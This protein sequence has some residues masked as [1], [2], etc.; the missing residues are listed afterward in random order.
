ME[1]GMD[2]QERVDMNELIK[3]A[4]GF[5]ESG[6]DRALEN[7]LIENNFELVL[8]DVQGKTLYN[9]KEAVNGGQQEDINKIMGEANQD[10]QIY[11][12]KYDENK[13][14]Q[15]AIAV[16]KNR[17][18]LAKFE[19]QVYRIKL[20]VWFLFVSFI[21]LQGLIFLVIYRN[22]LHPFHKLEH[23]ATEV[24]K[25]NFEDSL[26]YP[27]HNI[28][29]AFTW[30]FDMLRNELKVTKEREAEV[31]RTKK[32]LVAVL[33]HDIRTPIAS[34]RAYAECLNGLADRNS[35]R[36]ERYIHVII[37]KADELAKLSQD[38]FLHAISDLEKLEIHSVLCQSR[39]LINSIIEPLIMQYENRIIIT[40]QVPD[41]D[42]IVDGARL[43]QVFENILSN[44][45]KYA[46]GSQIQIAAS[47]KD[48]RL[49]CQFRDFGK[50]V[51][52]EDL[53]FIFDKFYRGRNAKASGEAGSGLGLYICNHILE[54]MDGIIKAYNVYDEGICGF[55]VEISIAIV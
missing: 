49:L 33:S 19:Q 3:N 12:V 30:S 50:G 34:I 35:E 39:G 27:R 51:L 44:A 45:A 17:E 46:S 54:K 26:I 42:V 16:I 29:G 32:E 41:V 53:P 14:M 11:I 9:S 40:S 31:E 13:S 2:G 6:S 47:I 52:P 24:A 43:A 20:A 4:Q 7:S 1:I 48:G 15:V 36:S 21:V 18:K 55:V 37:Q 10:Q 22:I 8:Y 38:L 5:L 28:F 25:G 23:F